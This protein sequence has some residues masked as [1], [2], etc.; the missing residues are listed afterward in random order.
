MFGTPVC[1]ALA[2]LDMASH[3]MSPGAWVPFAPSLIPRDHT[4][5]IETFSVSLP[6]AGHHF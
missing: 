6:L 1:C 4:V 3:P 2:G 5:A